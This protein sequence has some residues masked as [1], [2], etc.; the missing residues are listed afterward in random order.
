MT[1]LTCNVNNCIHN[2][3]AC[4]CKEGIKV[5]GNAATSAAATCCDS[6]QEKTGAFTNSVESPKQNLSVQCEACN[7]T[8]NESNM[9]AAE[10]ISIA[11]MNACTTSQTECN[12]FVPKL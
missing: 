9:C 10:S 6:F 8:Y 1:N 12:S 11:G 3:A 2:N 7:C 4:C 5:G